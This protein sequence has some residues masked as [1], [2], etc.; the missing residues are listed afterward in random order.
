MVD[1]GSKDAR[2]PQ[3]AWKWT[4]I[5]NSV[6]MH[7]SGLVVKFEKIGG[8]W[9]GAPVN[10]DTWFE[11]N[12]EALELELPQLLQEARSVFEWHCRVHEIE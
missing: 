5:S 11:G 12:H 4:V 3:A 6:V 9:Q 7:D 2:A 1:N 10:A 8:E